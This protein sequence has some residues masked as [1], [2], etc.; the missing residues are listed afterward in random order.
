MTLETLVKM[1]DVVYNN[2]ADVINRYDE[3]YGCYV[4]YIEKAVPAVLTDAF[5]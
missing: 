1:L 4:T 2:Y 5:T 3:M